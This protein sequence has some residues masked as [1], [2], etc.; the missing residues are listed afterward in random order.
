[1][2]LI[3]DAQ[4]G[5]IWGSF[6]WYEYMISLE[7]PIFW[8]EPPKIRSGGWQQYNRDQSVIYHYAREF[9]HR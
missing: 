6:L 2:G 1:M 8:V 9:R 5:N 7:R 3:V 4:I